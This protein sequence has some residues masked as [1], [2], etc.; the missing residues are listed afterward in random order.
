M[1]R[2]HNIFAFSKDLQN[3]NMSIA[4]G[5]NLHQIV[6]LGVENLLCIMRIPVFSIG[7]WIQ[8]IKSGLGSIPLN[9][10]FIY[11]ATGL[12]YPD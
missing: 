8:S 11:Q 7:N 10:H 9:P 12:E 5:S 6:T 2:T 1:L 4:N 3:T